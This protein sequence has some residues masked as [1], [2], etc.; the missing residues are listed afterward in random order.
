MDV[1]VESFLDRSE[2]DDQG[3]YAYWYEGK[4]TVFTFSD[5]RF[6]RSRQYSDTPHEA[7]LFFEDAGPLESDDETKQVVEWLKKAGIS[8]VRVL[9]GATGGYRPIW[10]HQEGS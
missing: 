4:I 7:N 6:L 3:A 8:D 5:G 1:S 2:P 10:T 9:G